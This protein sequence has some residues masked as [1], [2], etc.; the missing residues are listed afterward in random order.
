MAKQ[1][2][3]AFEKTNW[4]HRYTHG[5]NLRNHRAGRR[6]RP[7]KS[8]APIH[9]VLKANRECI[10]RGFR[11]PRRFLLIHRLR[12]RYAKRFLIKIEQMSVQGDHIHLI[13]RTN[14]RSGLQNFMRV[15][16]G[17]IAQQLQNA[18]FI[19]FVVT[20]T[21]ITEKLQTK[22]R[23]ALATKKR[24]SPQKLK[25]W[26]YRPFTRVVIGRRA[27]ITLENYVELN[28]KEAER[29]IPYRKER[30]RGL[31]KDEWEILWS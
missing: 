8:H 19:K 15:F 25:L 5:G 23:P 31:S 1:N 30:L 3:L 14:R 9:L 4:N 2:Q 7:I 18:G 24:V 26:M 22:T 28:E 12:D 29:A 6:E 16:S 21:Q 10:D 20:D 27:L 13:V 11:T 17:Q